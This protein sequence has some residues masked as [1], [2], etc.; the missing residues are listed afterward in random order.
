M[1]YN[2]LVSNQFFKFFTSFIDFFSMEL[3]AL[4]TS[5]TFCIFK[6]KRTMKIVSVLPVWDITAVGSYTAVGIYSTIYPLSGSW[7]KGGPCQMYL[8]IP[9]KWE[10]IRWNRKNTKFSFIYSLIH[11]MKFL[12]LKKM[13]EY[14]ECMWH[15]SLS[16]IHCNEFYIR[17]DLILYRMMD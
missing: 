1:F 13:K 17:I 9:D 12:H 6:D 8:F 10:S 7:V 16:Y 15:V 5:N 3:G 4:Q 2:H 11:K 14:F